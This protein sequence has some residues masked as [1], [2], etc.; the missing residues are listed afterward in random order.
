ML[1]YE[2]YSV[3]METNS[4]TDCSSNCFPF[5]YKMAVSLELATFE[6][7]SLFNLKSH[8]RNLN[9]NILFPFSGFTN[10][11]MN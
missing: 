11:K 4:L 10:T 5:A 3:D 2:R 7:L 9:E 6:L 8:E 1:C